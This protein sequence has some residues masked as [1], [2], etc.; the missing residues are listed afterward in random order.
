MGLTRNQLYGL[1]RTVGSNPTLSATKVLYFYMTVTEYLN[2]LPVERREVLQTVR[3]ALKPYWPK[4]IKEQ[5]QYGMIGYVVPLSVYPAGYLDDPK[6]PLPFAALAAQKN[7]YS[8]YLITIYQ[9]PSALKQLRDG[10]VKKGMKL[11]VGKSCLRFKSLA[12][13]DLEL[14]GQIIKKMSVKKYIE[15]Y[16]KSRKK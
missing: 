4:D 14:I 2:A 12:D 13:V 3:A 1:N 15:N 9:D 5:V 16:E 7:Y 6:Q 8:L 11:D 10:Y